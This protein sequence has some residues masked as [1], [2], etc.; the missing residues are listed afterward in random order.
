MS[1]LI[2]GLYYMY[3]RSMKLGN[4]FPIQYL[5]V[6]DMFPYFF[7]FVQ[8]PVRIYFRQVL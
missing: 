1:N 3:V 5:I 7:E 6:D 8:H 2:V 4:T